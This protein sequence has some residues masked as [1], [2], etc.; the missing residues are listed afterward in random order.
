MVSATS[1]IT[2]LISPPA[3][4]AAEFALIEI[5]PSAVVPVKATVA[6]V[7]LVIVT[8]G[9]CK[10][11][12]PLLIVQLS[13]FGLSIVPTKVSPARVTFIVGLIAP[14]SIFVTSILAPLV[15]VTTKVV[16]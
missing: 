9:S 12:V 1:T 13:V 5:D 4:T 2:A 11:V 15:T 16:K 14:R 10:V 7:E 6:V 3:L 8:T